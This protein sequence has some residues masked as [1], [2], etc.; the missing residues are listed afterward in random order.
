MSKEIQWRSI[1]TA[2]K[3]DDERLILLACFYK[4]RLMWAMAAT[5]A[6]SMYGY[7]QCA[8][9]SG[10]NVMQFP[11]MADGHYPAKY[12]NAEWIMDNGEMAPTH[13]MPLL[14][15]TEMKNNMRTTIVF[16]KDPS[17]QKCCLEQETEFG[18]ILSVA[19]GDSIAESYEYYRSLCDIS[20]SFTLAHEAEARAGAAEMQ[21][22]ID[23]PSQENTFGW[24]VISYCDKRNMEFRRSRLMRFE[25][26]ANACKKIWD[27]DYLSKYGK[28]KII[29]L[30]LGKECA[31][32]N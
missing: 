30:Y 12:V 24:V 16:E 18:K 9:R 20:G 29:P 6:V 13:W 19:A 10:W 2:P 22:I 21:Q 26:D 28:S 27:N 17:T 15:G 4:G 1:E 3:D 23:Q 32:N 8:S 7:I 5:W 25:V 14:G 11:K 31:E